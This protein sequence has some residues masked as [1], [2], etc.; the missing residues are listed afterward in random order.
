MSDHQAD[1]GVVLEQKKKVQQPKR[2]KVILLNDDY[3]SMEFVVFILERIF[4][5]SPQQAFS[6]MMSIHETGSGIAGVYSFEIA[7]MKIATVTELARKNDYPLH[8]VL[9]ED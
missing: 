9:E 5:K 3:T 4:H 7:E 2:F 8:C 6:L 1:Q